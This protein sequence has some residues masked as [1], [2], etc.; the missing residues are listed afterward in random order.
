MLNTLFGVMFFVML[1]TLGIDSAFSLVEAVTSGIRDKFGW[2]HKKC[3]LTTGCIGFGIG[4]LFISGAGLYWLD[5]VDYFMNFFGLALACL[6]ECVV[7]GWIFTT[8]KVADHVNAMPGLNI[9][10]WWEVM[11]KFIAPLILTIL[12]ITELVARIKS[13]YEGYPRGAELI[14][15]AVMFVIIPVAA[16]IFS[17][18]KGVGP[19][20]PE[21]SK[22]TK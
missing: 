14:G 20:D 18:L 15:A 10:K 4:L 17:R 7:I 19:G 8:T 5:I 16:I 3:N 1:L 21:L 11:I 6:I 12:L 13:P 9:G 22:K 2:S